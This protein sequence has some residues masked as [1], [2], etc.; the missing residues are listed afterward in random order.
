MPGTAAAPVPWGSAAAIRLRCLCSDEYLNRAINISEHIH[1]DEKSTSTREMRQPR[2]ARA[3]A[4]PSS[5][6]PAPTPPAL[7]RPAFPPALNRHPRAS[8]IHECSS[9]YFPN[10]QKHRE[11]VKRCSAFQRGAEHSYRMLCFHLFW[12][13]WLLGVVLTLREKIICLKTP[14]GLKSLIL[15]LRGTKNQEHRTQKL[16]Q[17]LVEWES[18]KACLFPQQ[19][20]PLISVVHLLQ[21]FLVASSS[22]GLSVGC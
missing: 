22:A 21:H 7:P 6:P 16:D 10:K 9:G 19:L 13:L 5:A 17:C 8:N 4:A 14:Q 3:G 20:P 15:H 18:M 11:N 1:P 2:R 12:G